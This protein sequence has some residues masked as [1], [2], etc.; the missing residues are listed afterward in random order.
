[1][2]V[3]P[4]VATFTEEERGG[5]LWGLSL[6]GAAA[7]AGGCSVVAVEFSILLYLREDFDRVD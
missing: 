2:G 4:P 7:V 3:P 5:A 6:T 1:M